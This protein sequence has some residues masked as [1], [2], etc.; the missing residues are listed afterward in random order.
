MMPSLEET[1]L[2]SLSESEMS[3]T[4]IR[5]PRQQTLRRFFAP[6]QP[7]SSMDMATVTQNVSTV[8]SLT[9]TQNSFPD[10]D[11]SGGSV[12]SGSTT[13]YSEEMQMDVPMDM[14]ANNGLSISTGK[15][16]VGGI[17]WM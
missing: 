11:V 8:C 6:T 12:T 10:T 3:D 13:P 17:G 14:G 9:T 2:N 5:D 4:E 16:W 7:S 1:S 15:T